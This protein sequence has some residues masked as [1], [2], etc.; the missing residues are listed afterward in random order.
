MSTVV[1]CIQ[2]SRWKWLRRWGTQTNPTHHC[3]MS[4]FIWAPAFACTWWKAKSNITCARRYGKLQPMRLDIA[5]ATFLQWSNK[6]WLGRVLL[7]WINIRGQAEL[8]NTALDIYRNALDGGMHQAV[9]TKMWLSTLCHRIGWKRNDSTL[10]QPLCCAGL[11][12]DRST[13]NQTA[14][15]HPWYFFHVLCMYMFNLIAETD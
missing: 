10:L 12:T 2:I 3:K 9:H 4:V 11:R 13:E 6:E 15:K 14:L 5:R 8:V 1:L 7:S